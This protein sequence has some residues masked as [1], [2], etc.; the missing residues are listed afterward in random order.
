MNLCRSFS[1]IHLGIK[2]LYVDL[3]STKFTQ[4]LP[5][6][7]VTTLKDIG[8]TDSTGPQQNT[9]YTGLELEHHCAWGF[10]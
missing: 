3:P 6:T 9:K 5:T 4:D 1:Y 2:Q 8:K 10:P 7:S